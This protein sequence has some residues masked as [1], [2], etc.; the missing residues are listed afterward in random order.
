MILNPKPHMKNKTNVQKVKALLHISVFVGEGVAGGVRV[1]TLRVKDERCNMILNPKPHM[2]NKT[3]VQKVKALL[4]LGLR[5][6]R[7]RRRG[8]GNYRYI[9]NELD[10]F[11]MKII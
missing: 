11:S 2:K 6:G 3:N 4:H 1:I 10:F 7:C 5:R 8:S 9:E